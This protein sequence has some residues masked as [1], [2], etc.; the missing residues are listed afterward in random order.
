MPGLKNNLEHAGSLSHRRAAVFNS[1]ENTKKTN[2]L[3]ERKIQII[4]QVV[5]PHPTQCKLVQ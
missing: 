3:L 4:L 5:I 2:Q 1:Q